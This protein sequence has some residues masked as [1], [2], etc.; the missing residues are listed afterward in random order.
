MLAILL[1][2]DVDIVAVTAEDEDPVE[3]RVKWRCLGIP[4]VVGLLATGVTAAPAVFSS[5][6]AG[7]QVN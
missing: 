3:D 6:R 2:V 7:G 5:I 1:T 4:P